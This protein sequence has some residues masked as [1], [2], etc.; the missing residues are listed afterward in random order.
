M[1]HAASPLI[2]RFPKTISRT[3][4]CCALAL[5]GAAHAQSLDPPVP[6]T[7]PDPYTQGMYGGVAQGPSTRS[8]FLGTLAALLAQGLGSALS[9]GLG[10]SITQWFTG[11]P[12]VGTTGA[13]AMGASAMGASST[14]ASP[15]GASPTGASQMGAGQS[16]PS[17]P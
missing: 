7:M 6:S 1:S 14:G 17:Q 15:T 5:A 2:A 16:L 10:G 3:A 13:S 8:V 12:R 11:K 9:Q 4:V